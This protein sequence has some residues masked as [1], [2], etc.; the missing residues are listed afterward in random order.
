MN[1]PPEPRLDALTSLRF[2]AAIWVVHYHYLSI[3]AATGPLA[4]VEQLRRWG[5]LGV[6]LFFVLSGF[7]LAWNYAG[8]RHPEGWSL[9]RF[10]A[11]RFAR[12]YPVYLLGLLMTVPIVSALDLD[13]G[14]VVR[15][16]AA[17]V[18]AVQSLIPSYFMSWNTP[19]W[20][21]STEACFYLLFPIFL[22]LGLPRLRPRALI[23]LAV[24]AWVL[25]MIPPIVYW[26]TQPDG[27]MADGV[28]GPWLAF[29]KY[30]PFTR[31]PEFLVGACLGRFHRIGSPAV[32]R[33]GTAM[34]IIAA[35]TLA[36]ILPICGEVLPPELRTGPLFAPLFVCM[37]LGLAHGSR[38]LARPG[39]ILLG[40]I[41]Y[42]VYILQRPV[43]IYWLVL[44]N[45]TDVQTTDPRDFLAYAAVLIVL[46]FAAHRYLERPA[47]ELVRRALSGSGSG[48][49]ATRTASDRTRGSDGASPPMS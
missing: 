33:F 13:R 1:R 34:W 15:S 20:S 11:A 3:E 27:A 39:L 18:F 16:L 49:G 7:I 19:G 41:S 5:Y 14:Y 43:R 21:I 37:V 17:N 31:F 42:A 25:G 8:D 47:R 9:R 24:A 38:P 48:T 22:A 10:W 32:A 40:E 4:Y 46:S 26:L 36:A 2:F 23:A 45:R 12:V 30:S 29:I 28:D 6:S 44:T 35:A